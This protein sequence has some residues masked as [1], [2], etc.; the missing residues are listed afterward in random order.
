MPDKYSQFLDLCA[1]WCLIHDTKGTLSEAYR[2]GIGQAAALFMVDGEFMYEVCSQ[3]FRWEPH[4]KKYEEFKKVL[5]LLRAEAGLSDESPLD[6]VR[7][8]EEAEVS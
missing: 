5:R 8:M 4:G 2:L 6:V 7:E 1:A 3:A